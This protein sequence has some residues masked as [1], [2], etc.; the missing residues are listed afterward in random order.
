MQVDGVDFDHGPVGGKGEVVTV[1][2]EL[3][4]RIEEFGFVTRFP[5]PLSGA[6]PPSRK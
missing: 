3:S 4:D 5:K 6:K 2:I 1:L